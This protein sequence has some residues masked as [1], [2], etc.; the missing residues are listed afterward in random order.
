MPLD[1]LSV[2]TDLPADLLA[3]TLAGVADG[4]TVQSGGRLVYA[5]DAAARLIGY[6]SAAAL[7]AAPTSEML[8]RFAIFDA[9]GDPLDLAALPGRQVLAGADVA[10]SVLR[11]RVLATGQE[12]WSLVRARRLLDSHGA[13]TGAISTFHDITALKAAEAAHEVARVHAERAQAEAEAARKTAEA[14]EQRARFLSDASIALARSLDVAATLV[15]VA[16]LAV[17]A[18]ADWCAIDLL[19]EG[20]LRRLVTVHRDP[21]KVALAEELRRRFP[22]DP[23]APTGPYRVV[24]TRQGEYISEVSEAMLVAGAA[25]PEHLA[26]LQSV[27][28]RSV[29][30]APLRAHDQVLGVLTLVTAESGRLYGAADFTFAQD[31][32]ARASLA[33]DNARL[34]E[35]AVVE[36]E[37][38]EITLAS[39]G[40][41]V[42]VT[43]A[44]GRITFLNRAAADLTGWSP[45]A[46][47]GRLCEEVF[48][49]RSGETGR[50]AENPL[51]RVLREGRTVGLAN[52][53]LLIAANG[54][55]YQIADSGAPIRDA[56]GTIVGAVLV[57]RDVTAEY[58]AAAAQARLVALVDSAEDAILSKT[59]DGTITSW[60]PGA[61]ALYGYTA[62]EV[63]GRPVSMLMPD[64]RADDAPSI[65]ARIA[66]GESV[67]HYETLRQRKDGSLFEVS[68]TVSPIRD[69]RG[70]IIGA[71]AIARDITARKEVQRREAALAEASA[72]LL[73]S[74]DHATLI[75]QIAA[76]PL[77]ALA[78]VCILALVDANGLLL[79]VAAAGVD[80]A[81]GGPIEQQVLEEVLATG[82]SRLI[83]RP[84]NA[85]ALAPWGLGSAAAVP[86]MGRDRIQGILTF[87]RRTQHPAYAQTDLPVLE[88]LATR[89]AL[90]LENA[91]LYQEAQAAISVRDQFLAVAAHELKTPL[92]SLLAAVQLV[93]RRLGNAGALT[94][95]DERALRLAGLQATRLTRMI[96]GLLDV[97]RIEAGRLSLEQEPLELS[98]LAQQVVGELQVSGHER[99]VTLT[100]SDESLW[101]NGDPLRLEQVIQNL[102]SNGLKYSPPEAPVAVDLTGT[103]TTVCLTVSDRGIGIPADA[104]PHVFGRFYRGANVAP[105]VGGMGIGLYVVSEIVSLHG[106]AVTVEST[107]GQGS[108]FTVTLPRRPAPEV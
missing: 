64:S 74:L 99:A 33:L 86:L 44:G 26:I 34:Y 107:E 8:A 60:N 23:A 56:T 46:A 63:I 20:A 39:V 80:S 68:L 40:D 14:A 19:K 17:P 11:Y 42:I 35:L 57:F 102:V 87:G 50:E 103:A 21:A 104:L 71:S 98:A 41:G 52:D 6:P 61:A 89:A 82:R 45:N 38:A 58:Q 108:R 79:P 32:A 25:D 27:G 84:A 75:N 30:L 65:L 24:R 29:I 92:T 54:A 1:P 100:V 69:V 77:P 5:N 12:A 47:A 53:T 7:L 48:R 16:N 37:R 13:V 28:L 88:E 78:D 15:Q 85:T 83:G 70:R 94:E 2:A 43:D 51:E 93:Q 49:I 97:S 62:D 95:R 59:L 22:P 105:T 3:H 67:E 55:E 106:G 10:E 90:A 91:R 72:R 81:S 4:I 73:K 36:R 76:A 18:I 101:V 96:N 31:L 66:A 9:N